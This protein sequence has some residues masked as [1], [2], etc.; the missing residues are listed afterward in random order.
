MFIFYINFPFIADQV[1]K[2]ETV[3]LSFAIYDEFDSPYWRFSWYM[4][5]YTV[6]ILSACLSFRL[7]NYL[8]LCLDKVSRNF[9]DLS[10]GCWH[11]VS[12]IPKEE[13]IGQNSLCNLFMVRKMENYH[14]TEGSALSGSVNLNI[15]KCSIKR[16]SSW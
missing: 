1:T 6:D 10:F 2:V 5:I 7:Q 15:L 14:R 3:N 9:M 13:H 8:N 4:S 12:C 16:I 11:N